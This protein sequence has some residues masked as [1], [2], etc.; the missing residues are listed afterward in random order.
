MTDAKPLWDGSPA[1]QCQASCYCPVPELCRNLTAE[2]VQA[3][4]EKR[5]AAGI[6][7][8]RTPHDGITVITYESTHDTRQ[9]TANDVRSDRPGTT[10]H[11]TF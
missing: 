7:E 5:E 4:R 10:G 2:Q 9:E 11:H 3:E 8:V 1:Q 6:I